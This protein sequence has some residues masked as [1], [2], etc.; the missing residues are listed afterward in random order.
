MHKYFCMSENANKYKVWIFQSILWQNYK[1]IYSTYER[2]EVI[3]HLNQQ[4]FIR[5]YFIK[6]PCHIHMRQ[7]VKPTPASCLQ[8]EAA[9][10][11]WN[12]CY[13]YLGAAILCLYT[14]RLASRR[15]FKSWRWGFGFIRF[16]CCVSQG[17]K[18]R[19]Y[20]VLDNDKDPRAMLVICLLYTFLSSVYKYALS[21]LFSSHISL[22]LSIYVSP[23]LSMSRTSFFLQVTSFSPVIFHNIVS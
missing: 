10:R 18:L 19:I 15:L 6:G 12:P 11:S 2:I 8:F 16:G 17:L 22:S 4:Y 21:S 13:T 20:L 7:L 5:L 14:H 1:I 3:Q 9:S 23:F